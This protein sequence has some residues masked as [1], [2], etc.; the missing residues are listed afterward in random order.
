MN[1]TLIGNQGNYL[2]MDLMNR[3]MS[4]AGRPYDADDAQA[5]SS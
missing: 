1:L 4:L 5:V 2:F 3:A